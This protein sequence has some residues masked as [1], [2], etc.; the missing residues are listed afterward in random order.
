METVGSV[1]AAASERNVA[2]YKRSANMQLG[3]EMTYLVIGSK[4][5]FVGFMVGINKSQY[6]WNWK[7]IEKV[8]QLRAFSSMTATVIV[9]PDASPTLVA[10]AFQRFEVPNAKRG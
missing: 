1:W 7:H 5:S 2:N 6:Q 10:E 8:S 4:Q 3:S 9:L